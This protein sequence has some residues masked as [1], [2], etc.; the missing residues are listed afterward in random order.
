MEAEHPCP[1]LL[2]SLSNGEIPAEELSLASILASMSL[3]IA[4]SWVQPYCYVSLGHHDAHGMGNF[5]SC[6]RISNY[7]WCYTI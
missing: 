4:H 3:C 6:H 1:V 5:R 7:L 2:G